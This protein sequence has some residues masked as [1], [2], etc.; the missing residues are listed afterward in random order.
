MKN[1]QLMAMEFNSMLPPDQTPANTEGYDGFFHLIGSHG[2]CEY[3]ELVYIIRDHDKTK[4]AEKKALF[5]DVAEKI[6]QKYGEG[7]CT[8]FVKDSYYN[9]KEIILPHMEI[10]ELAEKAM[11]EA[12]VIPNIVPIRGG[13]DGAKLSFKGLPCPN[14]CAGG[15]NAHSH[16]EYIPLEDMEKCVQ[17]L[18]NIAYGAPTH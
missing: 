7:S 17:I 18:L 9:M 3:A 12:G 14:L 15:E 11:R 5:A 10:I 4:F 13:T 2:D 16:L 1:A 6:A 8:A